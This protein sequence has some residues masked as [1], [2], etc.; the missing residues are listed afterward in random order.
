VEDAASRGSRTALQLGFDAPGK[1]WA[2]VLAK[3]LVCNETIG[4]FRVDEETVHI[5]DAGAD[6]GEAER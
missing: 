5:E 3:D 1:V 6:R 2:V 4:I